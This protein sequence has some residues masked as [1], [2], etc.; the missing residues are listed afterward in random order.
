LYRDTAND[1]EVRVLA[2]S[3]VVGQVMTTTAPN[4]I[5]WQTP[6]GVTGQTTFLV[7]PSAPQPIATSALSSFTTV[8]W[9]TETIDT[10]ANFATPVYTLPVTGIYF[11]AAILEW[12]VS[13]K[14]NKGE[15]HAEIAEDP[16]GGGENV[17]VLVKEQPNSNKLISFYQQLSIM[18]SGVATET[19][20]V[21][22]SQDS[23]VT[24]DIGVQSRF[25][26]W[27]IA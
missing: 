10:G 8:A 25:Y 20:G 9:G 23:G 5:G 16:G 17:L 21:R 12:A 1:N 7:R 4:V 19:V 26:G 24:N 13:A 22:V 6:S 27:R 15:R 3:A 18:Y 14:S 11:F 2:A